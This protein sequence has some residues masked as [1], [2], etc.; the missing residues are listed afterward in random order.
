MNLNDN[1]QNELVMDWNNNPVISAKSKGGVIVL[2]NPFQN[3][4][5]TGISTWPPSEI[6]QKL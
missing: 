2:V 4:I 6:V 3:L 5:S 1:K